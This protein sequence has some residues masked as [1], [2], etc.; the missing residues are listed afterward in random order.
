MATV[1]ALKL[2]PHSLD[3][4]Q[5]VLG[6]LLIDNEAWDAI[7][8]LLHEGDFYRADHRLIFSALQALGN[9]S[10][11][12]DVITVSEWLDKQGQLAEAG[13]LEYLGLLARNV[14]SAAN[15]KAYANIVRE[16][17]AL[18]SLIATGTE[19]TDLGFN[20][21]GRNPDELIEDA[22]RKVY[23]IADHRQRGQ[24]GPRMISSVVAGTL[25]QIEKAMEAGSNITGLATGL[26]DFDEMTCGLQNGDLV[27][28][29]GR[30]SMGKTSFAMNLVEHICIR[31]KKPTA[32]F[33]MEMPGEQLALRMI[34]SLG[35][36]DQQTLRKGS[37]RDG[38][39]ARV[40][41]TV[42]LMSEAPLFIDDTGML[43]PSEIRARARRLKRGKDGLALIVVDYLQLMHVPGTNENRTTEVS[44]ISRGLKA[45]A[46]ELNVPVIALS[47]LNR[48]V[49]QRPDKRPMMS[50]LRESGSIEQDAD[51]IVFLYRDEVYNKETERKGVAEVIIGK[52]R[53][54]PIGT[55]DTTFIRE[56]TRF[57]NMA[58]GDYSSYDS[59]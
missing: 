7:S 8:S 18:R 9:H 39:W 21:E 50:D 4:E 15:I 59:E 22:E 17:S 28:V 34:S 11:P 12:C 13:G 35:R 25:D 45:L 2:P 38:D 20:P 43:S 56:Y 27:I 44:E 57:E 33:S 6:G 19:I 40:M 14:P 42:G 31:N 49:E 47:Q 24:T 48:S 51:L 16:K 10:Q 30:P 29:A 26:N 53:N 32:V 58:R 5:S 55:V 41:S 1:N 54:G 23:A 36:V 3:A 46:K 37:V 52:Q